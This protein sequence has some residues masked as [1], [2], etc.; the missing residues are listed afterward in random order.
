MVLDG[1][2]DVGYNLAGYAN[3]VAARQAN[4]MFEDR[5]KEFRRS[6]EHRTYVVL[7]AAEDIEAGTEIR[8][9]YDM[10][11]STHPFR[12][13]MLAAGMTDLDSSAYKDTRWV[14]PGSTRKEAAQERVVKT[15]RTR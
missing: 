1:D 11:C 5:A 7:L 12:D 4:G 6:A 3:Y 8:V 2:P 13:Q 9:D 15:R 10:G 14:Y